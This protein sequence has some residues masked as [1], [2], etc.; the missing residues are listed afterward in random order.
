[1]R[2]ALRIASNPTP[3]PL[4]FGPDTALCDIRNCEIATK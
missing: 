3:A 1:M 2:R 4:P